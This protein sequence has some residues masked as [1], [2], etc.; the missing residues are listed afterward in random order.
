[1]CWSKITFLTLAF[2]I[3][4]CPLPYHHLASST[5]GVVEGGEHFF[6]AVHFSAKTTQLSLIIITVLKNGRNIAIAINVWEVE[7][8]N[9]ISYFEIHKSLIIHLKHLK[10]TWILLAYE[11]IDPKLYFYG[12]ESIVYLIIIIVWWLSTDLYHKRGRERKKSWEPMQLCY[13]LLTK[14]F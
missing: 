5:S 12:F 14:P 1:M 10:K 13:Y 3:V 11:M 7:W 4:M 8:K 9:K 2:V 6:G